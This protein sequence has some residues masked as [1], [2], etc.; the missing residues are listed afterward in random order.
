[1]LVCL[2]G[3]SWFHTKKPLPPEPTEL[4]VTGA[5]SSSILFIDGVQIREVNEAGNRPQVLQVA[6]GTHTL[7]VK[8]GDKVAYRENL[9]IDVGEKRVITVLSGTTRN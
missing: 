1:M 3:C 5:P 8:T 4:V 2:S 6:P 7:E 9:D